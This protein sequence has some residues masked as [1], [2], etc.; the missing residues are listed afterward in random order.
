MYTPI[1]EKFAFLDALI[2]AII[3]ILLVFLVLTLIILIASAFS[4]FIVMI[5]NKKYIKPRIEN[6]ILEEDEDAVVATL[7]ASIDYYRETKKNARVVSIT[8]EEEE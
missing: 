6:K 8:R 3:A 7:V 5:E 1:G 2:V 4:K